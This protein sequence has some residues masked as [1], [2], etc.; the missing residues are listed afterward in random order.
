MTGNRDLRIH[1]IANTGDDTTDEEL[2]QGDMAWEG[3]DLD[4]HAKDHNSSTRE[5]HPTSTHAITK[6]ESVDGTRQTSEF[7]D[8]RH[9]RLHRRIV[10]GGCE[11]IVE[12]YITDNTRHDALLSIVSLRSNPSQL[13]SRLKTR[14]LRSYPKSKK[15]MV[16]TVEIV[17]DS[18]LPDKPAKFGGIMD[19]R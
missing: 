12:G 10:L 16:A 17:K 2:Q 6:H 5:D 14:H 4:D 7:V 19:V 13:S 15:P 1:A 9:E 8:G 18:F 3:C 11:Y